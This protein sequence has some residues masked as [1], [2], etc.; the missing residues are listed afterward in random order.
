LGTVYEIADAQNIAS[1]IVDPDGKGMNDHWSKTSYDLLTGTILHCMYRAANQYKKGLRNVPYSSLYEVVSELA[2]PNKTE[3]REIFE[4]W[5]E[6]GHYTDDEGNPKPNPDWD[7]QSAHPAVAQ[8]AADMIGREDKEASSVLSTA[9]SYLTLYRDPIL[10]KNTKTSSFRVM[11]LMNADKPVSLYLTLK[12]AD[13]DRLRPFIRLFLT[14]VVKV[15]ANEMEYVDG[16]SKMLHKH[17]LLLLLDEFP[18]LGRLEVLE[19]GVSYTRSFGIKFYLITQD[20]NQLYKAYTKEESFSS[21]C[22]IRIAYAPNKVET[23]ELLSKMSGTT[24]AEMTTES[25]SGP[26]G[27][28]GKKSSSIQRQAVQRPLLTVDECMRLP[29]ALKEGSGRIVK[30]GAMLV[31]PQGFAPIMGRQ[32][33][34]FLD[35]VFRERAKERAPTQSDAIQ[36]IKEPSDTAGPTPSAEVKTFTSA[37]ETEASGSKEG[38]NSNESDAKLAQSNAMIARVKELSPEER[39]AILSPTIRNVIQS[40]LFAGMK[41]AS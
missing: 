15:L 18:S 11:D 39:L 1:I 4:A 24:T 38:S 13:L 5:L 14:Q 36:K 35:P 30:A 26:I 32:I 21:N 17:P 8:Y 12:P 20:L 6:Y 23:A 29:G 2:D 27:G 34:Y 37:E 7:N 3:F 25:I 31:F 22:A 10:A 40:V 9:K 33:L 19:K 41:A 28:F 16:Q